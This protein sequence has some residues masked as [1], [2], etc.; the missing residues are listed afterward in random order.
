MSEH[1]ANR[2]A[3]LVAERK[4]REAAA[5][6]SASV[7]DAAVMT[8]AASN[9]DQ[10]HALLAEERARW[11]SSSRVTKALD[12]LMKF[13][14]WLPELREYACANRNAKQFCLTW[15]RVDLSFGDFK[16]C[17]HHSKPDYVARRRLAARLL[18]NISR[19]LFLAWKTQLESEAVPAAAAATADVAIEKPTKK[20]KQV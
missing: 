18:A 13:D 3:A 20:A 10:L 14:T 12:C 9:F 15:K 1:W 17:F 4:A 2:L 16:T 6:A 19:P 5:I 8:A 11:M 7:T